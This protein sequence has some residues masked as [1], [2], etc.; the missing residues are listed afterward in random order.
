MPTQTDLDA[1]G[2]LIVDGHRVHVVDVGDRDSE[3]CFVLIH[4]IGVS[5]GYYWPLIRRLAKHA[6][7]VALDLPGFGASSRP[8][9]TLT[10][11]DFA[12]VVA[13]VMEQLEVS[14]PVLV[15]HSMGGQVAAELDGRRPGWA[16]GMVL[17]GPT[18]DPGK[19][20]TFWHFVMLAHNA[21][22]EPAR[23]NYPMAKDYLRCGIRQYVK[24]LRPM[25]RHHIE[26][27][28]EGAR[29]PTVVVR[30]G[31]DRV[32]LHKWALSASRMPEDGR[33]VEVPGRAH[34]VHV[35]ETERVAEVCVEVLAGSSS[36]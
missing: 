14:R 7:V 10:M 20:A 31:R 25:L 19:R 13:G 22:Y 36:S 16:A 32:V 28:L 8:A 29:T 18:V 30:G 15:G 6:R 5:S 35:T 24:T 4:G 11:S 12:D 2:E 17:I 27:R 23:V 9:E 33:L 26:H 1:L 3:R 34:A 21:L